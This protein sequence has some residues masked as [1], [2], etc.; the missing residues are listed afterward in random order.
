MIHAFETKWG[1]SKPGS[2]GLVFHADHMTV[3]V[4]E[5]D[6]GFQVSMENDP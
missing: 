3:Q 4:A 6:S 1:A 5:L 2:P